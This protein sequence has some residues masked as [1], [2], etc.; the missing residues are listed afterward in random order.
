VIDQQRVN[1]GNGWAVYQVGPAYF[2]RAGD[3]TELQGPYSTAAQAESAA[4]F[5]AARTAGR[6]LHGHR[7]AGWKQCG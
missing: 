4:R 3:G 6:K 7:L 2:Y 1:A 5:H